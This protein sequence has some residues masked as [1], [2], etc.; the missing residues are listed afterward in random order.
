MAADIFTLKADEM[1]VIA[2]IILIMGI[3]TRNNIW[4]Y[5]AHFILPTIFYEIH[6]KL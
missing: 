3:E 1:T 6:Q 5:I 4:Y 2:L